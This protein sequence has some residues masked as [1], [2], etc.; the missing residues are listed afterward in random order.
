[1]NPKFQ[2]VRG[3]RDILGEEA[4][5]KKRIEQIISQTAETY[6][7]EPM[8][9]PVLENLDLLTIKGGGGEEV[10]KELYTLEDRAGRK[11]GM[12]FEFTTSLARVVASNPDL[13]KPIKTFNMGTVYR[14]NNPQAFRFREFTQADCDI[15]GS[16]SPLADAECA[17]FAIDVMKKI[18]FKDFYVRVNDRRLMSE[19]LIL[20]GVPATK[21]KETM[22]ILD[23][24]DKIGEKNVKKE[25]EEKKIPTSVLNYLNAPLKKIKTELE[26]KKMNMEGIEALETF[27]E[28]IRKTGKEKYV[29]FDPSMVRGLEYYTGITFEVFSGINA[30]VGGGGRYDNLI[31]DLGGPFL[32]AVGISFGIDRLTSSIEKK[33]TNQRGV[34]LIP[35]GETQEE[36]FALV[37]EL[38]EKGIKAE[39]DMQK[40]NVG[41]NMNYANAKKIPIVLFLGED[42]LK[43]NVVKA[44]NMKTGEEELVKITP[45]KKLFEYL[46][47][48]LGEK[49]NNPTRSKTS[50]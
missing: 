13:P 43:K 27:F 25:L 44:R 22:R 11:L 45:V 5:L 20:T 6:G 2:P 10:E 18:G 32:P 31:K 41:K 21:A 14:Y 38:R 29:R 50:F 19:L 42:E 7:F 33:E 34:Y 15:I 24:L 3:M 46:E 39:M 48:K 26:K 35:I 40:R 1:M 16:N 23:K 37:S 9:T 4:I 12:R 47:K 28:Q 30:S 8:Q 17:L 36:A 49:E